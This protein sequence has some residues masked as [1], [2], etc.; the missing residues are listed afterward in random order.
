MKKGI[1]ISTHQ[2]NLTEEDWR[3]LKDNG[4]EF[5]ILRIG[6]TGYGTEK[7]KQIDDQFENN[8]AMCKKV[9]MPVGGYWY[10]CATSPEEAIEEANYTLQYLK[11][12]KLEYPV[13]IDTE[14]NHDIEKYAPE[15]QFSI[16]KERLTEVIRAYCLHMEQN[17]YYVGIYASLSWLENQLNDEE[18]K[19]YDK[20][21]AQWAPQCTY[22]GSYGM[23][24]YTNKGEVLDM[25]LDMNESY[26]DFEKIMKERGLNGFAVVPEVE[27]EHEIE[28]KPI[29]E[30]LAVGDRVKIIGTG[31]ATTYGTGKTAKGI[32]WEREILRIY[33]N[34]EYPYRVGNNKG[35]TGFYK[36]SALK[37][38]TE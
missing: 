28:P 27:P 16:G 8:Y 6:Y 14:D 36:A 25:S 24:Q 26:Y 3:N 11:D 2:G 38:I 31:K 5:A 12:K 22:K 35:T 9:G 30:E 33:P 15:S 20:W 23:W 17:K 37:K 7:S 21:V 10:S 18:L 29:P 13:Y 34:R 4:I 32:G 19:L 1:D